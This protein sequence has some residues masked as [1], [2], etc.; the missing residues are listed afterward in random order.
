MNP[1][2]TIL[3]NLM[4]GHGEPINDPKAFLLF[5]FPANKKQIAKLCHDD[6][7]EWYQH[8]FEVAGRQGKIPVELTTPEFERF[9][10]W[11]VW[12]PMRI[13]RL[14]FRIKNFEVFK[15]YK[16]ISEMRPKLKKHAI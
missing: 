6:K 13:K 10:K 15:K 2:M 5:E 16:H 4:N 11:Q 14:Y 8:R 3:S 12:L 1:N 9:W 7:L